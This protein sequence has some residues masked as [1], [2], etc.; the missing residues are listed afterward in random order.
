MSCHTTTNSFYKQNHE[1]LSGEYNSVAFESVHKDWLEYLPEKKGLVM[2]V[3]AGSGRDALWLEKQ[4][5]RVVAVEPVKEF[6][7]YF[8][9]SNPYSRIHWCQD[10]LPALALLNAYKNQVSL[11]LLSAV[12]MHLTSQERAQSFQR[13]SQLNMSEGLLI[14]TLRHGKSPDERIMYPVSLAEIEVLAKDF[15]YHIKAVKGSNDQ[16]QRSDVFWETVIM[17]KGL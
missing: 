3:G 17:Q 10:A 13:L 16:L 4:G 1:Q 11:V 6:A 8:K 7:Q 2:D 5:Y 9:R 15:Q 14:I 12:W